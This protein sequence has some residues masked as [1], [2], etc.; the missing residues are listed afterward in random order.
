LK[1]TSV[2]LW[3]M[4]S[5]ARSGTKRTGGRRRNVR[6]K[7]KSELG[8]SP[9]ETRVGEVRLKTVETRGG[10]TKTRALQTDVANVATGGEV[11]TATIENVVEND[12]N[13]NYVRRNIVT[14]GAVVDTSE[15]RA[16][17]T[18]RPGQDG[19]VNAVLVE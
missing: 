18:S 12:A 19:Q 8:S 7:R 11:V 4:K 2:P 17:V 9:T 5:H 13:P 1:A 10:N 15:G 16:R 14:R 3:G 6:K